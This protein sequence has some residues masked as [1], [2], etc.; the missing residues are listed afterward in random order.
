MNLL[1]HITDVRQSTSKNTRSPLVSKQKSQN[2][3]QDQN[4]EFSFFCNI[5]IIFRFSL[6][7]L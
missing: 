1:G 5:E 2:Q 3:N 6:K 7:L 4:H